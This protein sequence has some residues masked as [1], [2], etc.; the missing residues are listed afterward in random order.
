ML[1][2]YG[3]SLVY[4]AYYDRL[5][6]RAA[7]ISSTRTVYRTLYSTRIRRYYRYRQ[8]QILNNNLHPEHPYHVQ[9]Q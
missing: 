9:Y 6:V 5:P 4:F 2:N 8:Y 7:D 3:N 1:Y